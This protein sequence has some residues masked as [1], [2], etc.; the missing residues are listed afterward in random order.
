[1]FVPILL[2]EKWRHILAIELMEFPGRLDV[3]EKG[4]KRTWA[5]LLIVL[6]SWIDDSAAL[7]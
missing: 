6:I 7:Y 5:R 2:K 4:K 3:G 1:M